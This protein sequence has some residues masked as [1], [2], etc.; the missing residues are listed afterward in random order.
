MNAK[1]AILAL[2]VVFLG[3]WM[4]T[5]PKGLADAAQGAAAQ[6]WSLA[7]QLFSAVIDFVGALT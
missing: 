7:E 4:F 2:V 3:F 5:D 6:T 1:K